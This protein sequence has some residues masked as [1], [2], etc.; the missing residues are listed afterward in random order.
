MITNV[1]EQY[2]N[3]H[4]TPE[5]WKVAFITSIH[6]K[7]SKQDCH[8]YRGISVTSTM[9]RFYERILKDKIEE[10]Y[11]EHEEE[12]LVGFRAGRSHIDHI[13]LPQANN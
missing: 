11:A 2:L 9:S 12:E 13:F 8:N 3:G 5:E 1:F 7:G 6:K 4:D 10:E